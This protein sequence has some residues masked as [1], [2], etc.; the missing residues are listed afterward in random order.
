MLNNSKLNINPYEG[1][2]VS[3][4]QGQNI[5]FKDLELVKQF[6]KIGIEEVQHTCFV[7]GTQT[8]LQWAL[9]WACVRRGGAPRFRALSSTPSTPA[10][11]AHF[12]ASPPSQPRVA[13]VCGGGGGPFCSCDPSTFDVPGTRLIC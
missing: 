5:S 1:Y 9:V 10:Q 11:A 12:E 13:S 6:E 2:D 3:I 7:L 8:A 4:P